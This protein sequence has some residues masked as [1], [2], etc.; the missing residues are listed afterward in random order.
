[1]DEL[2]VWKDKVRK[3]QEQQEKEE[4]NKGSNLK[5]KKERRKTDQTQEASLHKR[6]IDLTQEKIEKIREIDLIHEKKEASPK[7]VGQEK[8]QVIQKT[9]KESILNK[10]LNLE[11]I[12]K[13]DLSLRINIKAKKTS[14]N[15]KKD[16]NQ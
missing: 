13:I 16:P 4:K 10:D 8:D 9:D 7:E 2:R 12:K 15:V 11:R 3:I 1:M 5:K 14:K 6:E